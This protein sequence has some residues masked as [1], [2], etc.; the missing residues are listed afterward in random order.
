MDPD[1]PGESNQCGSESE[2]L[3]TTDHTHSK[4]FVSLNSENCFLFFSSSKDNFDKNIQFMQEATWLP[5]GLPREEEEE[6]G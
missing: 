5:P 2:T 4:R 3:H 6:G 1:Y